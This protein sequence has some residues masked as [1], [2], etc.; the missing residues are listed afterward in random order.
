MPYDPNQPRVPAGSDK[1]GEWTSDQIATATRAMYEGANLQVNLAGGWKSEYQEIYDK[2]YELGKTARSKGLT[3]DTIFYDN[4]TRSKIERANNDNL[5]FFYSGFRGHEKPYPVI[6][7]RYGNFNEFSMNYA[8]QRPEMGVSMMEVWGVGKT[9]N[10][11]SAYFISRK[12]PD[13]KFVRG[14]LVTSETGSDGEPLMFLAHEITKSLYEQISGGKFKT[15]G[16][17]F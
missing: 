6:G 8:E 4:L 5:N 10:L 11:L 1:G 16:I 13:I 14:Y 9:Q 15:F 17:E 12:R 2:F 7:W 3:E